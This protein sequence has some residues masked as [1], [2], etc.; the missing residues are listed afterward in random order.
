[1]N[2]DFPSGLQVAVTYCPLTGSSLVFDR[3]VVEGATL[4]VSG[5]LFRNNLVI[6]DRNDPSSLWLQM[7]REARCGPADGTRLPMV[8]S[9]ETTWAGWKELHPETRVV[10]GSLGLGRDYTRY[11]YGSYE[12]D[13][14]LLFNQGTLDGRRFLKER[15]L[16]IPEE[17]GRH[18]IAF[19]FEALR[20]HSD[21]A[22]VV[23]T[24]ARGGDVVVFWDE[25]LVGA[26]AYRPE[27][28]GVH[29]TFRVEDGRIHDEQT[30]SEWR[31]DGLAV[32]GPLAGSSLE[33]V[34]EAFVA[35]WFA[36]A[37]FHPDTELWEG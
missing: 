19:P 18:G 5:I 7:G 26:M 35:F 28:E 4:G 29:L 1:M 11:P 2:V 30:G 12:Q 17:D 6:W 33:P 25:V 20:D 16:G 27:A 34:A 24:T 21:G 32:G 36:W 22:G 23:E 10:S 15:V 14:Q 3:S 13:L 9:I 31:L 8:A 37:A